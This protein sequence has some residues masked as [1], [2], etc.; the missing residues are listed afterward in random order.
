MMVLVLAIIGIGLLITG[1]M[2]SLM[3]GNYFFASQNLKTNQA[4]TLAE[5]G[6]DQT[7][8][9]IN[10]NPNYMGT[11]A[12]VSLNTGQF[13]VTVVTTADP[14]RREVT[15][16]GYVPS[17]IN[18]IAQKTVR[19]IISV[20]P[21]EE[22]VAFHYAIQSGSLG[23]I[24]G[25]NSEIKGNLFSNANIEVNSASAKVEGDAFA[26]G[27][28]TQ[29]KP[30]QITGQIQEHVQSQPLPVVNIDFWKNEA[31]KGGTHQG[32]L[33]NP[34]SVSLGPLEI[35]GRFQ[36]SQDCTI[37]ITGPIWVHGDI[38]LS[39]KGTFSVD[40]KF[41]ANGTIII[42]DGHIN[43]SGQYNF[44][45]TPQGGYLLFLSTSPDVPAISYSG[46]ATGSG[47]YYAY[48]GGMTVTGSG[49]M[50]AITGKGLNLSGSGSII[51]EEGLASAVFSSGP[52][53]IFTI[54]PGSWR[55]IP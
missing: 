44:V 12:P 49:K 53:G 45:R 26:V 2:L 11:S 24:V 50:A 31:K 42:S 27:T 17:K 14:N 34:G 51:Y 33:T 29:Q 10:A 15:A 48:N 6:I 21:N 30:G 5:A 55:E 13:E 52:G 46:T 39:G 38:N 23:I 37:N 18:P 40:S 19:V 25:G 20:T 47:A 54:M 32:D 43:I 7:I 1:A 36:I 3:S 28:V 41:G 9:Q 16:T 8:K 22:S 35:T 4:L